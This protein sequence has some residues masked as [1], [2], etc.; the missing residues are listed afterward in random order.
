MAIKNFFAAFG[1]ALSAI[2][3]SMPGQA[4]EMDSNIYDI[5]VGDLNNDG[6]KDYYFQGKDRYLILH[7]DIAIPIL[8]QAIPSFVIYHSAQGY[9]P[10]ESLSLTPSDL[11]S[12]V[13][14]GQLHLAI[15][16]TS[17]L[18]TSV[19]ALYWR[20]EV[21]GFTSVMLR[22]AGL[23]DPALLLVTTTYSDLPLVAGI[24]D[25]SASQPNLSDRAKVFTLQDVNS[26]GRRD[27]VYGTQSYLANY[28]GLINGAAVATSTLGAQVE[29]PF[30]TV[31]RYNVGGQQTGTISPDPDGFG[32]LHY[33]AVR[34]TYNANGLLEKIE[35]GD[36]EFW[37][38]E[39]IEPA[40]WTGFN[41]QTTKYF[42]YDSYGRNT[43]TAV[44]D[45]Q[46]NTKG[47]IQVNYDTS[48]HINCKAVR[49]NPSIYSAPTF[50]GLPDACT[51]TALSAFGYDRITQYAYNSYDQVLTEKR[52]LGTPVVQTY[53][54]NEYT[55]G[56]K[57]L[58]R[59]TDANGNVT[60]LHY[61]AFN[62]LERRVYPDKSTKGQINE[63]D[64]NQYGYDNNGNMN[65]ERKRN[66]KEINYVYD[67][68]NR[69]ILKDLVDNTYGADTQLQYDLRG[70]TLA[71]RFCDKS[72][73][74]VNC[75]STKPGITNNFD[76]FGRTISAANNVT[77]A[78]RTI[79]Y[80]Y[81]DNGNRTQV[82]HPDGKIFNYA[83][84]GLNRVISLTEQVST[85]VQ[86]EQIVGVEYGDNG[87]RAH[88]TR[89]GGATTNYYF[90][91]VSRLESFNQD[92]MGTGNDL[93]N[94][95]TYN[96]ANQIIALTQSNSIYSYQGNEDRTGKYTVNGLN[97][98]VTVNSQSMGYDTNGN[99]T[100]DG[101]G[102]SYLYDYENHLIGVSGTASASLKY[103]PLGH[104]YEA[105]INGVKTQFLYDGDA[106]I[107][108]YNSSGT[109]VR[110]YLH[111]DQVDEP[112]VEYDDANLGISNR[113]YLHTDHQ[114][115]IIAHSDGWGNV[116]ASLSYD[117][118]G[119]PAAANIERFGYTGQQWFKALG[120]DY[121]KARFYS[122]KLGRFLQTD[123]I[124]YKDDM[125]MYAYVGNDPV[126][127]TDP[128]GLFGVGDALNVGLAGIALV[129]SGGEM[130][131]GAVLTIVSGGA[132]LSGLG[133]APGVVGV[134]SG[135]AITAHGAYGVASALQDL[136][137]AVDGT[138]YGSP[139]E[140]MG[141]AIAGDN[142]R[143]LGEK[144]DKAITVLDAAKAT[145]TLA[146]GAVKT[147]GETLVNGQSVADGA[148]L[149]NE[150][151]DVNN[152]E[153]NSK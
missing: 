102:A 139:A 112:W 43:I 56:T 27:L 135:V 49:M 122:P 114:G 113:R 6:L 141:E 130:L 153:E 136:Q 97:Q 111:G 95:F 1:L 44:L 150:S 38:S 47:L 33:A 4:L 64:Y 116:L 137:N 98:Y 74:L 100:N 94:S 115:S 117:A 50:S 107:A 120:L 93:T 148:K 59:Q 73:S 52:G 108:E 70:L 24:Y 46:G 77:G 66:G 87:H 19:D 31:S 62:R 89:N 128:L 91:G 110:R 123:P 99:L 36:L 92:F 11:N 78:S 63:S 28:A 96:P 26:D 147:V 2:A 149:V 118:Y 40:N 133:T 109:L 67:N 21:N 105:T 55:L 10:A 30:T 17:L 143:E 68:N 79:N 126:N 34:N 69:Q 106:L 80:R 16:S 41:T 58:Y 51:Q 90:D 22:G 20:D 48:G 29:I 53:V 152:L 124:F 8:F 146:S 84:D 75:N 86:A 65:Y 83:F 101:A 134:L 121:Y 145:R 140:Q 37:Q 119:I 18:G 151:R 71:T 129:A 132:M 125:N 35:T 3:V 9:E 14:Q 7:G 127:R 60:E 32:P 76:G 25:Y 72:V 138:D 54:T 23:Y 142:G 81:D 57:R 82:T 131:G 42:V 45:N 5:Y 144:V 13:I 39:V 15:T 61:D 85:Q 88:L 103:D 12:R 104:L